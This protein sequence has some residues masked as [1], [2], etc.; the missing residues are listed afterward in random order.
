MKQNELKLR[1]LHVYFVTIMQR[2]IKF[3]G[4][5]QKNMIANYHTITIEMKFEDGEIFLN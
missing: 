3:F 5:E 4:R 1:Q 2:K